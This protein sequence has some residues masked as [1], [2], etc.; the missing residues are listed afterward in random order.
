LGFHWV[1]APRGVPWTGSSG[2]S[3]RG[4]PLAVGPQEIIHW[5]DSAEG[6]HLGFPLERVP[7]RWSLGWDPLE[8]VP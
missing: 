8:S 5:T 3:N 7:C 1:G 4:V 2:G 6:T